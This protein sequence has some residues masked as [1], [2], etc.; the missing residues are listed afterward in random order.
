MRAALALL[1]LALLPHCCL[2]SP[3]ELPHIIHIMGDDIGW[4]DVGYHN[5]LIASPWIDKLA[6][7][8][9][10]ACTRACRSSPPSCN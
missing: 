3:R 9:V 6:L 2:A 1:L 10:C 4:N 8:G 5:E 7:G